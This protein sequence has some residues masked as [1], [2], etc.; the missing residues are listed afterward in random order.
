MA[1]SFALP[2]AA[3]SPA[4][5]SA[6]P[7]RDK[8]KQPFASTSVWNMPIG[9]AATYVPASIAQATGWGMTVDQDI[10]VLEPNAPLTPVYFNGDGWS[11]G[12]RC[13][14]ALPNPFYSVPIPAGFIVPGATPADT[15]NHAAAIL[16]PDGRTIKQAQPFTRCAAGGPATVLARYPDVDIYGDGIP[17]AH[18]GSGLSSIGGTLRLGELVPGGEVPH[19]L[20]VN[21]DSTE[22]WGGSGPRFRWPATHA[23]TPNFYSGDVA[24]LKMGA[25]LAL[26]PALD[27]QTGA[28]LPTPLETQPAKMLCW[29]LQNYGAYVVD[30]TGW[31]V[32]ALATERSPQGDVETEFQAAWGFDMTPV[33]RNNPWSRDMDRI[34]GSLQVVDNNAANSVG[35]GGTPLQPLAPPIS[36]GPDTDLDGV[37]DALDNCP[38]I[39]NPRQQN[40]DAAVGNGPGIPGDDASV[41]AS[42]A[43]GE[44]DACET[45]GD[46]DN[47][48]LA[49]ASE[50][51]PAACAPFDLS[52]TLHASPI[53]GDITNDDDGDGNPAPPMGTDAGDDG[54]SWDTDNDGTLDGWEC[55]NGF[56]PRDA[57]SRPAAIIGDVDSDGDGLRDSWEVRGWGTN[58]NMLDSDG[59]GLGD[60]KEA[61]DVDG[62]SVVNFS[63]DVI[64]FAFAVLIPGYGKTQDF[65]LDKNGVANFSGDAIA[66]ARFALIAGLCK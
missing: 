66:A 2:A 40:T 65:D 3:L 13:T 9:S 34:F 18:G 37:S 31:N 5:E 59:D 62:N 47:D 61:A 41:P 35:G 21:L 1:F 53:G 58:P 49:D 50:L 36:P 51:S 29:T 23:D 63:G 15:P 44:G 46:T 11:G 32:Y 24:A 38:A 60:C 57:A 6:E 39:P 19:A 8:Y 16:L 25:L 7:A 27:C 22:L 55:A 10:I 54:P 64:A 52:G 17:G 56:D 20:K 4:A 12:D 14:P 26:L 48:G 30:T 43:D 33:S 42:A 28:G 45:D